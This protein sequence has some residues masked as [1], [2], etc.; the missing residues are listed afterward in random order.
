MRRGWMAALLLLAAGAAW[1]QQSQAPTTEEQE[2]RQPLLRI[3]VLQDPYDIASFY[4]SP[5]S[6]GPAVAPDAR[7]PIAGYYRSSESF[8][9]AFT[10]DGRYP[11]AGYYRSSQGRS[12]FL[13]GPG[14][15]WNAARSPRARRHFAS[16]HRS[17]F[18]LAPTV[19]APMGPLADSF[20]N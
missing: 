16:A 1:A 5:G 12:R 11:I 13:G 8:G 4:R 18:L 19:L 20:G 14:S 6:F 3:R 15:W 10:A 7:Y 2:A 17:V 9:G